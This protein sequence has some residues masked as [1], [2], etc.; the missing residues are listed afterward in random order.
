V[1]AAQPRDRQRRDVNTPE[2]LQ[3]RLDSVNDR[4]ANNRRVRN[5]DRA[6]TPFLFIRKPLPYP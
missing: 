5:N 2:R 4:S 1:S 3:R 6:L